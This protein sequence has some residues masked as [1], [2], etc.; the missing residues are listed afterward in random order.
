MSEKLDASALL[1][2]T[3]FASFQSALIC[4]ARPDRTRPGLSLI[5]LLACLWAHSVSPSL[6]YN[7]LTMCYGAATHKSP[8]PEVPRDFLKAYCCNR[9]QK[10]R[11]TAIL[12]EAERSTRPF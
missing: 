2:F 11:I 6:T 3:R 4:L 1:C 5:H 7:N 12:Q 9:R 8:W 10:F